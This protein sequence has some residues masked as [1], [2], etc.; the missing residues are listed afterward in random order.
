MQ[1]S[2][3]D[4]RG[5]TAIPKPLFRRRNKSKCLGWAEKYQ[6]FTVDDESKFEIH[7]SNRTVYVRRWTGQRII[8]QCVKLTVKHGE[9]H[10]HL[11]VFCSV[12]SRTPALN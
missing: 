11:G 10:L 8:L 12:W 2:Y 4:L 6:H 9:E 3:S 5:W 7:G 1:L